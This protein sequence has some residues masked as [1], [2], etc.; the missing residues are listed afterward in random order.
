[1]HQQRRLVRITVYARH[2]HLFKIY[3]ILAYL[4][5][6]NCGLMQGNLAKQLAKL[7][8]VKYVEDISLASRVGAS[9]CAWVSEL[10]TWIPELCMRVSDFCS[11]TGRAFCICGTV[12]CVPILI[13]CCCTSLSPTVSLAAF[14]E[15]ALERLQTTM[16]VSL[17]SLDLP[18]GNILIIYGVNFTMF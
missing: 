9:P 6:V 4:F 15:V 1:M 8:K 18:T 11:N 7:V 12:I 10:C 13:G 2:A 16:M 3:A 5:H 17:Q 14:V